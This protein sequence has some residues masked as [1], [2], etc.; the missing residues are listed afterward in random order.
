MCVCV[1]VCV[2]VISNDSEYAES[3]NFLTFNSLSE[4]TSDIHQLVKVETI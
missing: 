2:Y 3:W 4:G 1:C